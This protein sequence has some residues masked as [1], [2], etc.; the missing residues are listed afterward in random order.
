[1]AF[2][3]DTSA[4]AKLL[5]Q[6][7]ES[8]A[9]LSWIAASHQEIYSSDLLRVELMRVA[10]KLGLEALS[11]A[12]ILLRTISTIAITSEIL[13][14]AGILSPPSLRSLDALHIATALALGLELEGIITYDDRMAQAAANLGIAVIRPT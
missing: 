10:G 4:I 6:E 2:Y 5:H 9:L 12:R 13:D 14:S 1:M 8:A 11:Q 7:A 3:A